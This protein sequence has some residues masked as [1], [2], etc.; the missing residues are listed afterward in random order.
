MKAPLLPDDRVLTRNPS[1]HKTSR[2]APMHFKTCPRCQ[3]FIVREEYC[4]MKDSCHP[5]WIIGVR[6]ANCGFVSDPLIHHHHTIEQAEKPAPQPRRRR[7]YRR[8]DPIRSR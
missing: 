6:C 7:G 1:N 4:D 5:L 8:I 2:N 3:G